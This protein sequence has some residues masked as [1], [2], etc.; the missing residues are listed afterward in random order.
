MLQ[1]TVRQ[2]RQRRRCIACIACGLLQSVAQYCCCCRDGPCIR[3]CTTTTSSEE[4]EIPSHHEVALS[5]VEGRALEEVESTDNDARGAADLVL[6]R[7]QEGKGGGESASTTT[8]VGSPQQT[9]RGHRGASG[10]SGS[11]PKPC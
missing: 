11:A 6:Q 5:G 8:V 1:P 3:I 7:R 9:T 10:C 2:G 4:G